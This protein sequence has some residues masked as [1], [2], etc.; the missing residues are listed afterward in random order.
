[1]LDNGRYEPKVLGSVLSLSL[2]SRF[3][4]EEDVRAERPAAFG[5]CNGNPCASPESCA[6]ACDALLYDDEGDLGFNGLFC[7]IPILRG[8]VTLGLLIFSNTRT[9][10]NVF[11]SLKM[12]SLELINCMPVIPS[13]F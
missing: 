10:R 1:M 5:R 8:S 4:V 12:N 11:W 3:P 7:A 6:L 9:V 2:C 13:I